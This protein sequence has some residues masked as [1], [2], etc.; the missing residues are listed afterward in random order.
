MTKYQLFAGKT[1]EE[2]GGIGGIIFPFKHESYA[3]CQPPLD[4]HKGLKYFVNFEN[5]AGKLKEITAFTELALPPFKH[6]IP[7]FAYAVKIEE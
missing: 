4:P 2:A 3:I 1:K 6:A 7:P 5:R